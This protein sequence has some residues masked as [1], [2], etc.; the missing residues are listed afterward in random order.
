MMSRLNL[1]IAANSVILIAVL[2]V[3]GLGLLTGAVYVYLTPPVADPPPEE[4]EV[5]EIDVA[6]EDSAIVEDNTPLYS[7]GER[8]EGKSA[9][10][11]NASSTL[12]LEATVDVPDDRDVEVEQRLVLEERATRDERTFWSRE[13]LLAAEGTTVTDGETQLEGTIDVVQL[14]GEQAEVESVIETVARPTA[15]LRLETSYELETDDGEEYEGELYLTPDLEITSNAYWIDG[16]RTVSEAETRT[17]ERDP[18]EQ[19]PDMGQ[20][21]VLTIL[22]IALLLAAGIVARK[23]RELD[24]EELRL[25]TAHAEYGEWI[26]EGEVIV[27]S[28]SQYVYINSLEDLV[29]VGIDAD[30][31]VIYDPDLDVYTVADGNIVYYFAKDPTDL[32]LWAH[33]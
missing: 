21:S 23:S 30:K 14:R 18:I 10:F 16:D 8:L 2:V 3:L 15:Q 20:V 7:Q 29:N 32:E 25:E 6:L 33:V 31:R 1:H 11:L 19:S 28:D 22:G 5:F 4:Q 26:S 27:N 9:Y 12:T 17:I 13:R 24:V